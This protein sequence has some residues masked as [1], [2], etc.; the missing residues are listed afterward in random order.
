MV[1]DAYNGGVTFYQI[2]AGD[3]LATAWGKVFPGLFTPGDQMPADLRRHMR[4]PEDFFS[5]QADMLTTYHMTDP[6]LFYNKE[7]VWEIPTEIY[8]NSQEA[9]QTVPYYE[10]LALPGETQTEFALVLPFTPLSKQ[11]LSSLLVARQDGDNYGKLL[12][13]RLPQGQAGLRA[14]ADRGAHQQRA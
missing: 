3:P 11:N 10:V 1:I 13:I 8:E 12:T 4:Y 14:V 2:D 7:D 5:A 6:L 9:V